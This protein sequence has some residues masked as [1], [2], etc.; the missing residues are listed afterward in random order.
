[1]TKAERIRNTIRETKER[2]KALVPVVYQLKLQNL[3]RKKEETLERAFLEAKWL[4]N[5]LVADPARLDLPANGISEVEVKVGG[6][7][8]RGSSPSSAPRS[9]R[10]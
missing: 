8:R 3:S 10:K 9:S 7:S 5:W 6:S 1:M 4:Y 2:R